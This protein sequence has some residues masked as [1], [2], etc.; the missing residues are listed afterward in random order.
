MRVIMTGLRGFPDV[1]GGVERASE[2]LCSVLADLGCD[3]EVVMRSPYVPADAPREINGIRVCRIW[4]P[5]SKSLEALVHTFL[6][7]LYAAWRRPD[8]LHI[9]CIGPSIWTPLARLLGIRVVVVHH[10]LAYE[11]QKWGRFARLVLRIGERMAMRF[12]NERI[13]LTESLQDHIRRKHGRDSIVIPNGIALPE[14]AEGTATLRQFGLK[15]G[16]YVL[17]VGRMV[18]EKRHL[19]LIGA[20]TEARPKDWKLVLVGSSDHPDDYMRKVMAA[21]E[22]TP[23]VVATGIQTGRHL[24]ELYSH[25]GLFVLPSSH[26]GMSIALLEAISYG[27]PV[28][29][30]DIPA[31]RIAGLPSQSFYPLGDVPAL[32]RLLRDA[33]ALQLMAEQREEIRQWLAARYDWRVIG[34]Q[35]LEVYRAAARRKSL[36]PF[37]ELAP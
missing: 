14:I 12:S 31:N 3:V 4:S 13:T 29:V 10:G 33:D 15:P 2:R 32:A 21:V 24:D 35:T 7:V 18:P 26:E 5:R 9:Q 37:G 30:S 6:A 23:D 11:W 25:A 20:F 27:L 34:R 36:G 16:K 19:D 22:A 8:I 28:V 1:Q 17:L